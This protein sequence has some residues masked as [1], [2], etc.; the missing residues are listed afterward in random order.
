MLGTQ[1]AQAPSLNAAAD[2]VG[3]AIAAKLAAIFMIPSNEIDLSKPPAQYGIDSLVAVELRNMLVLQAAA[4][5][6]IF[7]IMQSASLAALALDV[8]AKSRHVSLSASA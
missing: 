8:V 5:V 7:N 6:S 2:L 4:E 3:E 1:L